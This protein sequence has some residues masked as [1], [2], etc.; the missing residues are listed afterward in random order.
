MQG[1]AAPP[2]GRPLI[3]P[4]H[5]AYCLLL[6]L[7]YPDVHMHLY[8]DDFGQKKEMLVKAGEF[9]KVSL[10]NSMHA[11]TIRLFW[12]GYDGAPENFQGG[13]DCSNLGASRTYIHSTA[14]RKV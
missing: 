5:A 14:L 6:L 1:L 2:R 4:S 12:F 10:P 8:V 13:W 11:R 7:T 9:Q 3:V